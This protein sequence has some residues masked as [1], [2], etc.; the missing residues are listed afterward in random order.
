MQLQDVGRYLCSGELKYTS[1][2]SGCLVKFTGISSTCE[3]PGLFQ[4]I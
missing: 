1:L 4:K 3:M 2:S